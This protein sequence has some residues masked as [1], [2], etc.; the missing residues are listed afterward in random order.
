LFIYDNFEGPQRLR[1]AAAA[2]AASFAGFHRL[3]VFGN[4]LDKDKKIA[5]TEKGIYNLRESDEY[6]DS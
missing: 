3:G 6:A 2:T 1:A 4:E 5:I